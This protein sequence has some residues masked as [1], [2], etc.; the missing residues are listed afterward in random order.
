MPAPELFSASI[1]VDNDLAEGAAV[2][3]VEGKVQVFQR[4]AG[5]DD[6]LDPGLIDGAGEI[7]K[8]PPVADADP[9]DDG[10]FQQQWPC[11]SGNVETLENADDRNSPMHGNGTDRLPEVGA[12]SDFQNMVGA[13]IAGEPVDG[14]NP[15]LLAAVDA[16]ISTER[17]CPC[18]VSCFLGWF[19]R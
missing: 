13:F 18:F 11:R 14:L 6:R 4:I 12:A 10:R 9:L 8:R 7:F 2:K 3:V 5:I 15:V 16:M 17:F 19:K 1:Q